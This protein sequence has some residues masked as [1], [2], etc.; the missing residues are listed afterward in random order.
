MATIEECQD[1]L[2][3]LSGALAGLDQDKRESAIAER[4]VSAYITDL[5]VMFNGRLDGDGFHDIT[6][7]PAPRAQLR[8]SMTSDDLVALADRELS[9]GTAWSRGRLKVDANVMDLLR[10]RKLF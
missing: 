5:D 4:S 10:L 1:A 9:F 7:E 8:L 2:A 6:T 3:R